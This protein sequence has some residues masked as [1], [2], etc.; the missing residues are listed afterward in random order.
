[1]P[2]ETPRADTKYSTMALALPV[3]G[4]GDTHGN[5]TAHHLPHALPTQQIQALLNLFPKSFSPFP[6]GTC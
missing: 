4:Q 5:L 1:M 3:A 6:H 2:K